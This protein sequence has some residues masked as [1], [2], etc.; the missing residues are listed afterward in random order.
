MAAQ[1]KT[2]PAASVRGASIAR[3]ERGEALARRWCGRPSSLHRGVSDRGCDPAWLERLERLAQ[4][5]QRPC[6]ERPELE[7]DRQLPRLR[8]TVRQA[9]SGTATHLADGKGVSLEPLLI[10]LFGLGLV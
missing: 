3:G 9:G 8:E 2:P 10:S 4:P 5:R 7:A 6:A 1:E